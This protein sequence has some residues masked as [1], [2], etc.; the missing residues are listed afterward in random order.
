[1]E[2]AALAMLGLLGLSGGELVLILVVIL[3]LFAA[4]WIPPAARSLGQSVGAGFGKPV[5]M[6]SRTQT[7]LGKFKT[8]PRSDCAESGRK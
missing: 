4:K 8:H 3:G 5:A 6:H 2:P 1:M 7:R